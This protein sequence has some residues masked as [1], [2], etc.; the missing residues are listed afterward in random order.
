MLV[1]NLCIHPR[2]FFFELYLKFQSSF[3]LFNICSFLLCKK[4][5]ELLFG[6]HFFHLYKMSWYRDN[7]KIRNLTN[8]IAWNINESPF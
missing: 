5:Q 8:F 6:E 3:I 4:Y 7:I 1:K 2:I